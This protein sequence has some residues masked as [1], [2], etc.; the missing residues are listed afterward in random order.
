MKRIHIYIYIYIYIYGG[1][2]ASSL[3]FTEVVSCKVRKEVISRVTSPPKPLHPKPLHPKQRSTWLPSLMNPEVPLVVASDDM[4]VS[5]SLG[6][7][8]RTGL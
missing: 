5:P 2:W 4:V 3:F 8:C 6:T 7:Q 1:A